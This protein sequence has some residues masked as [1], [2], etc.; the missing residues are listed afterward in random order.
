MVGMCIPLEMVGNNMVLYLLAFAI[1]F[2][3]LVCAVFL[4]LF[5]GVRNQYRRVDLDTLAERDRA[6]SDR[7]NDVLFR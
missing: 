3:V 1:I 2:I 4:H 7:L 5:L 6:Q